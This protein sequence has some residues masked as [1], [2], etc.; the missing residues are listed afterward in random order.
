MTNNTTN[1]TIDEIEDKLASPSVS[2]DFLAVLKDSSTNN[3]D[4]AELLYQYYL[5]VSDYNNAIYYLELSDKFNDSYAQLYLASLCQQGKHCEKD[6][7]RAQALFERSALNG[8]SEAQ[9]ELGANLILSA[10]NQE[11]I[12]QGTYWLNE[13]YLNGNDDSKLLLDAI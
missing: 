5:N 13:S 2:D 7:E 11:E 9:Y 1:L 3:A 6:E 8:D 4:I 10:N 12:E